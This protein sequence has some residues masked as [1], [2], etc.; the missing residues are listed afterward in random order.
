[1]SNNKL[2]KQGAI[3]GL[4]NRSYSDNPKS[5]STAKA[6]DI[7]HGID[8]T[9]L[10]VIPR[11][12]AEWITEAKE[13]RLTLRQA[14]DSYSLKGE[15]QLWMQSRENQELFALAWVVGYNIEKEQLYCVRI[16]N[17]HDPNWEHTV[18][19]KHDDKVYLSKTDS[20]KWYTYTTYQLT[21]AEIKQEF[22][23]AWQFAK[24]VEEYLCH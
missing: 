4:R 20:G 8:E 13:K 3:D 1:M 2:S 23:W 18:L 16:P 17:Q 14:L 24:P 5:I 19:G 10:P 11:Y 6:L 21:E 9:K 7:V 12:V 15:V 22:A